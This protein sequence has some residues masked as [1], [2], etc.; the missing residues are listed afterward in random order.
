MFY[1]RVS[2]LVAC[3]TNL[4][5]VDFIWPPK[6]SEQFLLH[7]LFYF[8][9]S[10]L[11]IQAVLDLG[12]ST[13]LAPPILGKLRTSSFKKQSGQSL[14]QIHTQCKKIDQSGMKVGSAL[15]SNGEW[16]FCVQIESAPA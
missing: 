6:F 12:Q 5:L 3:G 16:D 11:D 10:L 7:F 14:S 15:T 9:F 8:L 2:Q 13:I 1:N 4:A